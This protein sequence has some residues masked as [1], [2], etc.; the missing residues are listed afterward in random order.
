MIRRSRCREWG[1]EAELRVWGLGSGND[2]RNDNNG[3]R[4]ASPLPVQGRSRC[5]VIGLSI[6]SLTPD[7]AVQVLLIHRLRYPCQPG[8]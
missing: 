7:P 2:N 5:T 8:P 3:R 4:N 1:A 6:C